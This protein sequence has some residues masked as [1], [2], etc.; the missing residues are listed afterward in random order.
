[1]KGTRNAAGAALVIVLALAV[2]RA[3]GATINVTTTNDE[4]SSSPA[5]L[6]CALREAV[7]AANNNVAVGACPAGS[8]GLDTIVVPAGTYTLTIAGTGEDAS[9]TGDLDLKDT[10][11]IQGA[12]TSATTL[13]G[14]A[15]D[16]VIEVLGGAPATITGLTVRNGA[17]EGIA[18]DSASG[19]T[20]L[21]TVSVQSNAGIGV[22]NRGVMRIDGSTIRGN[23]Q[24]GIWNDCC[25]ASIRISDV[26]VEN[27][28]VT[29]SPFAA[30]FAWG[31]MTMDR[32]RIRNNTGVAGTAAVTT[33]STVS[34]ISNTTIENNSQFGLIGACSGL[35]CYLNTLSLDR[36]TVSGN[37]AGGIYLLATDLDTTNSTISGNTG[38]GLQLVASYAT[39]HHVTITEN[40]GL[41]IDN[42][43]YLYHG[44]DVKLSS[45]LIDGACATIAPNTTTSLGGNL[46]SP[47]NT[48]NLTALGDQVNVADPGLGPLAMNSGPTMTHLPSST[49]PALDMA[50]GT[51]PCPATDQRSIARP[52]GAACDVGA[53]E[54]S[55]SGCREGLEMAGLAPLTLGFARRRRARSSP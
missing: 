28:T 18:N 25:S 16:R 36:S 9:E 44:N 21:T 35:S 7:I 29:S 22:M 24:G 15:L 50:L 55:P 6:V 32:S 13:D 30:V 33:V 40:S 38:P 46:E 2:A 49:S 5:N 51:V 45:S 10:V 17:T 47:G 42:G 14:G 23:A 54:R 20:V 11:T 53:V 4:N 19:S 39:L 31:P 48:C 8:P 43:G 26:T 3:E 41:A 34:T 52:Y 1:M 12:G 27:N 37:H